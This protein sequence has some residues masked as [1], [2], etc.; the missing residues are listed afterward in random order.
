MGA[1]WAIWPRGTAPERSIVVLPFLNLSPDEDNEYFSDGLTEEIITR[2]AAVPELKVISR[3][4]AMHYKGSQKPLRQIADELDVAHVLEGSARR[5]DDHVRI[6][7]Q[8]IDARTDQHLWAQSYD[9]E[10]RDIFRVQEEI[11][12]EVVRTLEVELGER[13]QRALVRQGTR[14]PEA[15]DL[16]RRGRFLWSMRTKE[17]HEQ[18]MEY[19]QRAIGRDSTY[20]DAY[21]GLADVYLTSYQ[22][23]TSDRSEAEAYSR[24]KWA[25]ER[26]LA[27][28]DQSADAHA[29]FTVS[30]W[31]Q[32]NWPGAERELRRAIEL[33][34]G[35][36]QARAWYALLLAG[37]GRVEEALRESRRAYELDPFA[38]IISMTYG[39]ACY[40][41]R[42]YD[43]AIAQYRRTL[44][45]NNAWAPAHAAVGRAYAQ[46]GLHEEAIRAVRKAVELSPNSPDLLADLAF[47]Q[48]LAGEFEDARESLPRAGEQPW[49][50]FNIARAY[51]ALGE[52]DSA[53]AWLE[54]SS[55]Q[56]PNRGPARADP[57]L[58]PLRSDPR[59]AQLVAWVDR[60]MGIR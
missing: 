50:G 18:A 24:F 25:A 47:V 5:S 29:S 3:T 38:I 55:W 34:P 42:D 1:V 20:A 8:L 36:A 45:I 32:R 49:V 30:L 48:A 10:L 44:E 53:F 12:R 28:D 35:H 33:N 43:C 23:R 13:G 15:Y 60:E 56:W 31:W 11:A 7:A 27:L 58:D 54:R 57:A 41:A 52:P 39:W 14:D 59:F 37:M 21:S 9:Y 4:S 16:Y 19:F 22:L 6:T 46:K 51:V 40:L 26:A 2:L 17:G